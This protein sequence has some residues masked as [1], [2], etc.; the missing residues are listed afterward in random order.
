MN[1]GNL[2]DAAG[3]ELIEIKKLNFKWIPKYEFF[4]K[5]LNNNIFNFLCYLYGL[6][7]TKITQIIAIGKKK[8]K[9]Y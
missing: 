2:F 4:Y 5:I 9:N 8:I 7:N 1:L 6:T 3:F